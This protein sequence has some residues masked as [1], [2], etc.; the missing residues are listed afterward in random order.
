MNPLMKNF[1]AQPQVHTG[2]NLMNIVGMLKNGNPEQIAM[3]LMQRNPQ[4]AAFIR[5]NQ[6]KSPEQV[7][8]ERGIDFGQ[9]MQ[10]LR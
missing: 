10:M 1:Q 8:R 3:S 6:G 2:P 7:A 4:F 9:I 5:Q